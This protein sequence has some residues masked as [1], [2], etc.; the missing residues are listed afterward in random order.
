MAAHTQK[1]SG[2]PTCFTTATALIALKKAASLGVSYPEPL[3]KKA[4]DSILRQRNPDFSYDYSEELRYAPRYDINRPAGSLGRS[5]VCNL[6]LLTYGR[7][8]VSESIL[9]AWLNRLFARNGWLSIGRKLPVPHESEFMI[10]G[11]FY[12]Y[13]HYYAAMVIDKLPAEKRPYFQD[14]L[15]H[16][17]LPLQEKDGSWWDYP[18]YD[19]HQTWGTSMAVSALTR[20]RHEE[21]AAEVGG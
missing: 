11:Y 5:Q 19:Y 4:V 8:E 10:A 1:P 12:F 16:I 6:A 18:L 14:H 7:K 20:S 17:L 15:A 9:E 3:I 21:P 13:G 2:S